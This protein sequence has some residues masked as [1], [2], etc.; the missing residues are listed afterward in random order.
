MK[1]GFIAKHRSVW[2]LSPLLCNRCRA[3][4]GMA[5]RSAGCLEIRDP[6]LAA[7]RAELPD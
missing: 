5:M 6:C 7:S 2:P 3:R 1:F 4:G